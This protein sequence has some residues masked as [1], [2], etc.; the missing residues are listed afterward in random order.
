MN[1]PIGYIGIFI[2][3]VMAVGVAAQSSYGYP[4][5]IGQAVPAKWTHLYFSICVINDADAKH[6]KLFGR[7]VEEWKNAWPHFTYTINENKQ[8]CD[9]NV[10]L[11][12]ESVGLTKERHSEG[13]TKIMYG[14]PYGNIIRADILIPSQIK[15]EVKQV[16]THGDVCC[17]E[18]TYDVSEKKFYLIA[19]HEF[20]H[21][22]G[23][24]HAADDGDKEPFDVMQPVGDDFRHIISSIDLKALDDMYGT[25]TRAIDHPIKI[26]PSVAVEV[27]MDKDRYLSDD[28]VRISGKVST[29]SGTGTVMLLKLLDPMCLYTQ[30]NFKPNNDGS[31]TVNLDLNTDYNGKWVLLLQYLGVQ[32]SVVFD[33]DAIPYKAV[34]RSDRTSYSI[35]DVVKING[36]VTRYGDKVSI[37]A[38]NPNGI[39]FAHIVA[40]TS[41]DKKFSAEFTLRESNF[42]IEGKWTVRI[43]YAD[44]VS[45]ITFNVGK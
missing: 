10:N 24:G 18:L 16:S 42:T 5:S 12:K 34:G 33:V 17:T 13:T 38:V 41:P 29:I 21:A 9:I 26:G 40:P 6:E 32:K 35:G 8:D 23:L 31:F 2:A 43:S 44:T 20:G 4:T 25:S 36:N 45:T 11:T 22:L 3:I 19:L 28:T 14:H 39:N 37:I 1:R 27:K 15:K 7:A 30:T